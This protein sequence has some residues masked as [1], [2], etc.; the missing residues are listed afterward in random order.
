MGRSLLGVGMVVEQRRAEVMARVGRSRELAASCT[1]V[2]E[3]VA[4]VVQ[5]VI[6]ILAGVSSSH[7]QLATARRRSRW[8]LGRAGTSAGTLGRELLGLSRSPGLSGSFLLDPV[9]GVGIDEVATIFVPDAIASAVLTHANRAS[10]AD[11][12]STSSSTI[13]PVALLNA[14][15]LGVPGAVGAKR[16]FGEILERRGPLVLH[17]RWSVRLVPIGS[18]TLSG[19]RVGR[20]AVANPELREIIAVGG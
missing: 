11:M 1:R 8:L 7:A 14:T 3:V 16:V 5:V 15:V 9:Q 13:A 10:V 2:G 20:R 19:V 18:G 12:E 6:F 4:L 17:G